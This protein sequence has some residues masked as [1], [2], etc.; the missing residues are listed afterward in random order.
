MNESGLFRVTPL[1]AYL[2]LVAVLVL[3][4]ARVELL[5]RDGAKAHEALC[6]FKLDRARQLADTRIFIRELKSGEREQIPGI[7]IADLERTR[8]AQASTLAALRGLDC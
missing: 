8:I 1:A 3:G 5:A 4:M 7:T 2:I 6:A